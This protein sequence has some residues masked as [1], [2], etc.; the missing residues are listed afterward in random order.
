MQ[1]THVICK[2]AGQLKSGI[3]LVLVIVRK[4]ERLL[5]V[6]LQTVG[7]DCVVGERRQFN[8]LGMYTTLQRD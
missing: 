7:V 3:L 4:E 1:L 2:P 8:V 6:T 5:T